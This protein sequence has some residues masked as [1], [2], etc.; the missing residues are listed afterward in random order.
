MPAAL[1]RAAIAGDAPA[2]VRH[3]RAGDRLA[4]V[5]VI[6]AMEGYI[7]RMLWALAEDGIIPEDACH[8]PFGPQLDSE[9]R[10]GLAKVMSAI[11]VS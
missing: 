8:D 3:A 5:A 1:V 9:E 4:G 2:V 6:E 11:E 10:A 7:R